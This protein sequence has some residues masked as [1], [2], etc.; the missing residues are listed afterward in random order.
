MSNPSR[1][2]GREFSRVPFQTSVCLKTGGQEYQASSTRD[3]SM[4]GMFLVGVPPL[5]LGSE[6]EVLLQLKGVE[7]PVEIRLHGKIQRLEETGCAVQFDQI[8]LESYEHLQNLVRL[9]AQDPSKLELEMG[10]HVG[11]NRR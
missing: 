11:L 8:P 2:E 6:C 4:K 9:N 1:Q 5:T 10:R 3:I 7:P